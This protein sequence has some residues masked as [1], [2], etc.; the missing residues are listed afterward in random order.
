MSKSMLLESPYEEDQADPGVFAEIGN[1]LNGRSAVSTIVI[2]TPENPLG[3]KI[4]DEENAERRDQFETA[5]Q[6]AGQQLIPIVGKYGAEENSYILPGMSR[7]EAID[8]GGDFNQD[9]VIYGEKKN[10]P[11]GDAIEFQMIYTS[12]GTDYDKEAG[13]RYVAVSGE[14]ADARDDL[15]SKYK[16]IKFFIPFYEP[17]Y[18]GVYPWDLNE[19]PELEKAQGI[20]VSVEP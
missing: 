17:E 14:A 18:E 19:Q 6:K 8:Y 12:K 20:E 7:K 3:K 13:L 5:M 4:S 2:M 1:M 10:F 9:S 15:F 16:G 11:D